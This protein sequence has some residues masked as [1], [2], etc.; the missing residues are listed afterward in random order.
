[1]DIIDSTELFDEV[2]AYYIVA[3]RAFNGRAGSPS[4]PHGFLGESALSF[5]Q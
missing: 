4:Q 5:Y 2:I 1:L 3:I